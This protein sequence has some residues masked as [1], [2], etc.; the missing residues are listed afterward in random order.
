MSARLR[1]AFFSALLVLAV[2][3]PILGLKL[4]T[5]GVNLEVHGATPRT[6]WIVALAAVLMFVWQLVRDQ[7]TAGWRRSGG[8]PLPATGLGTKLTE[9]KTQRWVILGLVLVALVWPFYGSRGAVDIATLILIYVMLGLG[10]NIVVGLAGLL[11]LGYVGFYAVGAYTYAMLSHYYG[12]DF[13][14]CLPLAGLMAALFGFLLGFPVLRLRGDYLAIVT[15]GFGEIIR[16][17]LRNLTEWTGGPN[18]ISG[19]DKPTLFGL[20]FERRAPEGMTPF[21]EYFGIPYNSEY[22]VIF[23]YLIALLLVLLTLFVI[24]RLLRMP[25]GRAWEALREDEIACRALG[26]NPT[27]I[28]LSAFT[29]GA[30]FAGFAGSFFAAR[31]GLVSPESFTFIES[32]IILAIVVLGGMGSQLGVILAAIVMILLPELMREFSEYRML[33]FGL[34]MVVMMIWRPQGLLPMQRPH[35]ELRK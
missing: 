18:G 25:I 22:K 28:K 16:I 26:L 35:L 19:I 17:L 4:E 32:A 21:H 1:T 33:M 9:P 3:Y 11:D 10:L 34:L 2:A 31:Q 12:L 6:L 23:L 29:L 7:V 30:C 14:V 20:T 27:L 15:L 8:L 5:V 13:W 24:N